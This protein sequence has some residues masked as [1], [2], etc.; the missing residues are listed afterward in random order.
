MKNKMNSKMRRTLKYIGVIFFIAGIV[1]FITSYFAVGVP[2]SVSSVNAPGLSLRISHS[3][4]NAGLLFASVDPVLIQ[5]HTYNFSLS[6]TNTGSVSFTGYATLRI[7]TPN[8]KYQ[9]ESGNSGYLGAD[10]GTGIVQDCINGGLNS[11]N[12][13]VNMKSWSLSNSGA[14]TRIAYGPDSDIATVEYPIT[15]SPGQTV[16][17]YFSVTPPSG[18]P[19]GQYKMLYN[20]VANA[21]GVSKVVG[22]QI[23][24]IDVGTI[25]GTF[26]VEELGFIAL[27]A[28]GLLAIALASL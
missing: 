8:S 24:D 9:T 28:I 25:A 15:I 23:L 21:G 7:A 14:G 2:L 6:I 11:S 4:P 19:S 12:C 5:N 26:S 18:I 3:N 22:Y 10:G 16:T 20:F 13:L 27:A 1:A 17:S